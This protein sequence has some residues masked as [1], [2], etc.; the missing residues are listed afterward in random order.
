MA[1]PAAGTEA[2]SEADTEVDTV[3]CTEAEAEAEAGT[4]P[5]RGTG[6]RRPRMRWRSPEQCG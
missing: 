6:W 1:A 4:W 2:G 3:V 5:R